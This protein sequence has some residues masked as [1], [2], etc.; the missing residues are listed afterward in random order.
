MSIVVVCFLIILDELICID[1]IR[2][3]IMFYIF[4]YFVIKIGGIVRMKL[5]ILCIVI[6]ELLLVLDNC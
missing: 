2:D 6:D 4:D 1:M 3:K 5:N